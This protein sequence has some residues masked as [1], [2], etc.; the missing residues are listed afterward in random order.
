MDSPTLSR[1]VYMGRRI[2]VTRNAMSELGNVADGAH[3][4][5]PDTP[6]PQGGQPHL[7]DDK[8]EAEKNT[9]PKTF[10]DQISSFLKS[11]RAV[12]V[13]AVV[14]IAII[15]GIYVLQRDIKAPAVILDQI[16]VPKR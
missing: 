6:A 14:I 15:A 13:D 8:N 16:D 12:L 11:F 10:L 7:E 4:E 3:R 2:L 5:N 9:E 1:I